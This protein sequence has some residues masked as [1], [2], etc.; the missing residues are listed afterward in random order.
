M[1]ML[2]KIQEIGQEQDSG[3]D[4]VLAKHKPGSRKMKNNV[5]FWVKYLVVGEEMTTK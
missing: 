5:K 2:E 1:Q 4:E 3:P